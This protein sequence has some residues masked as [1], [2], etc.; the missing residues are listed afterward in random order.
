MCRKFA[1]GATMFWHFVA[2]R[3]ALR[4]VA[5]FA[6][7]LYD[8]GNINQPDFMDQYIER[9]VDLL[10]PSLNRIYNMAVDEA[11]QR[12]LS[13]K[14]EAVREIDGSFALLARFA[15]SGPAWV[16]IVDLDGAK[17]G[18]PRQHE[19]IGRLAASKPVRIQAGGGV[20]RRT[21]MTR[22]TRYHRPL[23]V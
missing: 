11:R 15:E 12:V 20:R 18:T 2:A 21:G 6:G 8:G 4:P 23:T 16:H 10:D 9:V 1:A 7:L 17:A 13:G 22:P 3:D 5:K 19:T 14:P